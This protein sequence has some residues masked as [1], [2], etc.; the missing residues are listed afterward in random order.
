MTALTGRTLDAT[1]KDLLQVSN[2]NAGIDATLRTVG[3]GEDTAST[4]KLSSA[5][6]Q[7][8]GA[9]FL[10]LTSGAD[11]TAALVAFI[12]A[13]GTNATVMIAAP[14]TYTISGAD[15]SAYAFRLV[16]GPGVVFKQKNA[17]SAPMLT[18]GSN[19]IVDGVEFDGNKANQ[20]A[21][22]QIIFAANPTRLVVRNCTFS[23]CKY[24]G[25]HVAGGQRCTIENNTLTDLDNVAIN[26]LT[27][28]A[29]GTNYN[30]IR[31][32][33]I[34]RSSNGATDN[35]CIELNYSA[36]GS[37]NY[38]AITGNVCVMSN[39]P[40]GANAAALEIWGA[41]RGNRISGNHVT[42]GEQ[43][44]SVANTQTDTA[45]TGNTVYDANGQGIEIA[46]ASRCTVSGN[47][48]D[49]ANNTI[50]GIVVDAT[51]S[52]ADFNAVS[53]NHV[54]QCTSRGIYVYNGAKYTTVSGNTI[55][56]PS[57]TDGGIH[58]E[59]V[60]DLAIVGNVIDGATTSAAGIVIRNS[61]RWTVVGNAGDRNGKSVQIV[62]SNGGAHAGGTIAA[63]ETGDDQIQIIESSGSM[64]DVIC[65]PNRGDIPYNVTAA[66]FSR[67]RAAYGS[68]IWAGGNY[69]G[70]PEGN[71][72]GA[73]GSLI[74]DTTN[75][76]L[77][78]K[79]SG[80]GTTG[81]VVAGTQT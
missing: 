46:N 60:S 10:S 24:Y 65:E 76:K 4:I 6:A 71:I 79:A 64:T 33:Y 45:V 25:I 29:Y 36:A 52:A 50:S 38:N 81:W 26:F 20:A 18:L 54:Y 78:I 80:T 77:Y 74:V 41:G 30:A 15:L 49:G 58:A 34:D 23:S 13:V 57:A 37:I 66:R 43:G 8:S 21:N 55:Y 3:D 14:G 44:I 1:Y 70:T 31:G 75:G 67:R 72:D 27:T 12:A 19:T 63:N 11:C 68:S 28:G 51:S 32:N 53:G 16:G 17:A 7:I 2:A 69:A 61:S 40:T 62:A 22:H 9:S 48:V 73:P 47:V 39:A 5:A 59:L 56:H 35:G 42:G